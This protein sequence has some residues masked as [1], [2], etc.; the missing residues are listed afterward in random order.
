LA[1]LTLTLCGLANLHYIY[2]P[3]F[4]IYNMAKQQADG[5]SKSSNG[6]FSLPAS[7][8][9]ELKRTI[10]GYAGKGE[11]KSLSDVHRL[12]GVS[13]S[14]ISRNNGFLTEAGLITAGKTKNATDLGK[15]LGRAFEYNRAE[16]IASSLRTV[17]QQT[18]FLSSLPSIIRVQGGMTQENLHKHILFA[19]GSSNNTY[20]IAGAHAIIQLLQESGLVVD[21]NGTF[22]VKTTTDSEA[23]NNPQDSA[24]QADEPKPIVTAPSQEGNLRWSSQAGEKRDVSFSRHGKERKPR[25]AA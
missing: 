12:S 16:E 11:A 24:V 5:K 8:F 14:L 21:D 2:T 6:E 13:E 7:S 15:R 1:K 10:Q 3:T 20:K 9:E 25:Q 17:V 22:R 23:E 19:S 4:N 18:E